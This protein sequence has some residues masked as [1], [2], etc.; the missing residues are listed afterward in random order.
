MTM[1]GQHAKVA[2]RSGR[3]DL[4][5]VFTHQEFIR[6]HHFQQE[7]SRGDGCACIRHYRLYPS[8]SAFSMASSI[9]PTM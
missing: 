4:V 3:G 2:F 9:A 8:F 1:A 7:F 6:C 5:H